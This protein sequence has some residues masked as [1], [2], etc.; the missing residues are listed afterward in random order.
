MFVGFLI[1]QIFPDRLLMIFNAS[2]H[3]TAIGEPALRIISLHFLIAGVSVVC[4]SLFQA[5]SHG[6]LSLIVSVARQ[7]VVLL[8]AAFLLSRTGSLDAVWWAFPIAEV[9]SLLLCAVFL[10]RV[11]RSQIRPLGQP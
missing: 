1:F 5:L 9:A 4:S 3:M 8:P 10:R 11:Y 6:V 2:E 7:L